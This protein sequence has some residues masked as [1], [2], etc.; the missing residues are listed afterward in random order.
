MAKKDFY[1]SKRCLKNLEGVHPDLV[2]VVKWAIKQS[3]HDFTVV[4][5]VR[6]VER[7]QSL[8]AIG[9]DGKGGAIATN[10]DG[11]NKK[12]NHQPKDDGFGYAVDI[13]PF[14]DGYVRINESYVPFMLKRIAKHVKEI[15]AQLGYTVVW[16][17]DWKFKDIAHFE[18]KK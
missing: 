12:S 10:C 15:A 16:G 7:Q 1:L 8:Y 11:V 2:K 17:G 13:Y 4:E 5:G 14:V 3:P 18:L 6:T 9:R